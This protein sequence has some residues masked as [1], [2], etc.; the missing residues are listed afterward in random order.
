MRVKLIAGLV[1]IFMGL[2]FACS[3]G[4]SESEVVRLIQQ[5][6]TPGPQGE[7]GPIGEKGDTGE[8]GPQGEPGPIGEKGDTGERGPQGEPG[9]IGEKGDTGERGPQ[10]EPGPIGERGDTG[11]Q[12]E[13]GERGEQGEQGLQ[14]EKGERGEAGPQ[15]PKGD[16][17][18]RGEPGKAGPVSEPT[19][20]LTPVA[21]PS[22]AAI[23]PAERD[24]AAL[25]AFYNATGGDSWNISRHNWLSDLPLDHWHGVTTDADGR[26]VKLLLYGVGLNGKI[27]PELGSLTELTDLSLYPG[28]RGTI[29][30]ELGNLVSL[31]YL[32]L[33][34]NVLIGEIPPEM[35]NLRQ[36]EFLDLSQ[37]KLKGEI[38]EE[39]TDLWRLEYLYLYSSHSRDNFTGCIPF[40]LKNVIESDLDILELPFCEPPDTQPHL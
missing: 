5:H 34:G 22:P 30:P 4:L 40:K 35:G 17:G 33:S 12:G 16:K 3:N 38:P 23:N 19:V 29:P 21:S 26:V 24:R 10:G 9:P 32:D 37:N 20:V 2:C 36:L 31:S 6:S 25:V 7:P 14:G 1:I 8:R 27:P 39:L 15:G 28:I 13:R 11:Q 18:D